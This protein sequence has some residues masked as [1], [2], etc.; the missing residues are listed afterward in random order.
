[1][2]LPV[3]VERMEQYRETARMRRHERENCLKY[4]RDRALEI[5]AEAATI[6]RQYF[7]VERIVLFG[8]LVSPDGFH[9]RSDI[10]LVVWGLAE[11][12]HYRAVARLLE[13]DHEISVDIIRAEAAKASLLERI[14]REGMPL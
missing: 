6:L 1:M 7:S 3:P 12:D 11:R 13:L 9:W 5:A 8:S 10:D 14:A 2:K 4:R